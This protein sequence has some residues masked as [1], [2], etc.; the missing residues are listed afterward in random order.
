MV[1]W[2]TTE[3]EIPTGFPSAGISTSEFEG[4]NSVGFLGS[5]VKGIASVGVGI[6]TGNP[7]AGVATY[8]ALSSKG[9]SSAPVVQP[10]P[11]FIAPTVPVNFNPT[12]TGGAGGGPINSFA[13]PT[14]SV[15]LTK[16]KSVIHRAK[17]KKVVRHTA[18]AK[19]KKKA[20][21]KFGSPAWRKKYLGHK[22]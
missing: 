6:A 17:K 3:Q 7:L 11:T 20:K 4:G 16:S 9:G 21:L 15:S 22:K 19:P 13:P 1:F 14:T 5:L 10:P 8:T 12:Y 18:K 2:A